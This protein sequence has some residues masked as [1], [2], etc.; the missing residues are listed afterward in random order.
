[1]FDIP[2]L[3]Q[4]LSEMGKNKFRKMYSALAVCKEFDNRQNGFSYNT[5][6]SFLKGN[7]DNLFA[8]FLYKN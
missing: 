7:F 3:K 8:P 4:S 2:Q 6:A 5:L 1:M